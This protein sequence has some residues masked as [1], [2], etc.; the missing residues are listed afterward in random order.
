MRFLLV[1]KILAFSPGESI[2]GIKQVTSNAYYVCSDEAG[3]L[4]FIPSLIG[5]ALGQLAAW[6]VMKWYDFTLRPVAGMVTSA[7]LLRP[8]YV[9]ETLFLESFIDCL[10]DKAVQYH[11]IATIDKEEVFR[12]EGALGPLLPMDDFI[13]PSEAARQWD[14][15]MH[16]SDGVCPQPK[17]AS[18][19]I[20]SKYIAFDKIIH[21]EAG[22][23]LCGEKVICEDAPY[24]PDHFPRKQVFPL[25]ILLACTM[26]L[27]KVFLAQSPWSHLTQVQEMRRIK[28]S[29]FVYPGDTL[30]CQITVK[31]SVEGQVLLHCRSEVNGKRVCLLDIVM[32]SARS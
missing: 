19:R 26:Q 14:A 4:Q 5:E 29:E 2:Q 1:D 13:D 11:S 20:P 32:G 15:V 23:S 9:G 28:M 22:V 31:H 17:Q 12:I 25:T 24:F 16:A 8:A 27:A 30:R 7:V 6:N 3:R 18:S 21:Y 10:D